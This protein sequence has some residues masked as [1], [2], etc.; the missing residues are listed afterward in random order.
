MRP[1]GLFPLTHLRARG[2]ERAVQ[3]DY[4]SQQTLRRTLPP[5]AAPAARA[6]GKCSPWTGTG[7]WNGVPP[8]VYLEGTELQSFAG[9]LGEPRRLFVPAGSWVSG[10]LSSWMLGLLSF[11][12]P[13]RYPQPVPA[14]PCPCSDP[15]RAACPF[16]SGPADITAGGWWVLARLRAPRRLQDPAPLCARLLLRGPRPG[17]PPPASSSRPD[18]RL[19]PTPGQ[20]P[21]F[22]RVP[23][24]CPCRLFFSGS[25]LSLS[26]SLSLS[27]SLFLP[28]S[29]SLGLSI[30]QPKGL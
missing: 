25:L 23:Q 18:P 6:D 16:K 5:S 14:A 2:V 15:R 1:P 3:I 28:T 21:S 10:T 19:R 7:Q 13:P 22:I 20:S 9:S 27:F 8:S 29:R 17:T 12:A 26:L 4:T 30:S 11:P 24:D